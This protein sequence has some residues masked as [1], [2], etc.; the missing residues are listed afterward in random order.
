M[1]GRPLT[2]CLLME[3]VKNWKGTRKRRTGCVGESCSRVAI[4]IVL[5]WCQWQL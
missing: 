4:V 2:A 1:A 3:M 5:A